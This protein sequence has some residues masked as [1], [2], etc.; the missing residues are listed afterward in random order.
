HRCWIHHMFNRGAAVGAERTNRRI[1]TGR[2]QVAT[3]WSMPHPTDGEGQTD[4]E[5]Q[6]RCA[7]VEPPG[8]CRQ[9][10]RPDGSARPSPAARVRSASSST[11]KSKVYERSTLLP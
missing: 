2:A 3:M 4:R 8:W 10:W 11:V 1:A 6:P 5:A 9:E 7:I